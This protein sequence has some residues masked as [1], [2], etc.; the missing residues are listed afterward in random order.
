MD[1]VDSHL[2]QELSILEPMTLVRCCGVVL[3]LTKEHN[4][5]SFV[6]KISLIQSAIQPEV[7]KQ[8]SLKTK[9]FTN[10]YS[11]LRGGRVW[12]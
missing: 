10:F 5:F 3:S 8:P 2:I 11:C 6:C 9:K 12:L 7:Q 4:F 1:K